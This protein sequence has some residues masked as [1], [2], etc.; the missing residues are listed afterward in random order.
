M[1]PTIWLKFGLIIRQ[2]FDQSPAVVWIDLGAEKRFPIVL[3]KVVR[4]RF[5]L[6]RGRPLDSASEALRVDV[7]VV[8]GTRGCRGC[9]GRFGDKLDSLESVRAEELERDSMARHEVSGLLVGGLRG[10]ICDL[11]I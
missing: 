7:S 8:C 5:D 2:K 9:R 11:V 3:E 6:C 1:G 4:P 10:L